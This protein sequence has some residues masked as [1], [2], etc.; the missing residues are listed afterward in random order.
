VRLTGGIGLGRLDEAASNLAC[1]SGLNVVGKRH[2][3]DVNTS[4][5]FAGF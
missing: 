4:V 3:F 2:S 1:Q 5:S